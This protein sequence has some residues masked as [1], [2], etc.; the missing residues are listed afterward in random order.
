MKISIQIDRLKK[1]DEMIE[2]KIEIRC[3]SLKKKHKK[4]YDRNINTFKKKHLK[5]SF[6]LKTFFA[7]F[8]ISNFE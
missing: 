7:F 1:F 6:K 3:F 8:S 2:E 5:I 4:I